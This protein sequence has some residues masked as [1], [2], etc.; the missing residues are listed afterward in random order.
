MQYL[1]PIYQTHID[2]MPGLP[3][4]V[5]AVRGPWGT[6]LIDT[7]ISAMKDQILALGQQLGG[8]R[9]TLITHA[10]VDHIGCNQ[11]VREA[12]QP[13]FLAGGA[14]PWI[15]DMEAHYRAFC[16]PELL[17]DSPQQRAEI[18]GLVDGAVS[19]DLVIGEG[20][21]IRLGDGIELQTLALPGHKLEEIGFLETSTQTLI[22]GDVLLALVAPFFHG[23]Q[24][25]RGFHASLNRLQELL[26]SGRAQRVLAAHHLPLQPEEALGVIG[27][28]RQFLLDL[29][30]A[31]LEAANTVPFDQLWRAVCQRMNKQLEFRG[32]AMLMDQ[33]DELVQAGRL[34]RVDGRITRS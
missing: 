15:E 13:V 17:P 4:C 25:A 2:L 26:E 20:T 11:A 34:I 5:Y 24:T 28:T 1:G 8:V 32:Y 10:H 19:V 12:F 29:E 31:T 6:A 23:F 30:E 27:A 7:G 22:V 3:L 18:L 9:Y 14:L 21:Q 16:L 33:V